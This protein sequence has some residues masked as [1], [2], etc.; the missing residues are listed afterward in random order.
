MK[1]P[2]DERG[3]TFLRTL[4]NLSE[5]HQKFF[6]AGGEIKKTKSYFNVIHKAIFDIPIEQVDKR[7]IFSKIF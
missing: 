1:L 2:R 3:P 6:Y 5:Q 7:K 4:E